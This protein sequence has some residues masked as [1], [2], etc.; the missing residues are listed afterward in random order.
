MFTKKSDYSILSL[1]LGLG[2]LYLLFPSINPSGDTVTYA[3]NIRSGDELFYPHHLLYNAFYY[4]FAE[5]L[6]SGNTLRLICAGNA[7][8]AAGCLFLVNAIL[9]SAVERKMRAAVILLLGSCF[10]FMRYAT[11]GETYIVPLFFL[12]AGSFLAFRK[13]NVFWVAL[14]AS[15]ACL[16]HQIC[17]FWWLGLLLFILMSDN[18]KWFRALTVY[19]FT[20]CIIPAVYLLVFYLTENDA[21]SI[22]DY[23]VHDYTHSEGVDFS[24]KTKA[25]LLTPIN[26]IRT[27][28]QV[29]GYILP[30]VQKY[31]FL[32]I[33]GCISG[34]LAIAGCIRWRKRSVGVN[35]V[36][37]ERKFALI[38]LVIFGLQL[39]FAF[40]S[41]GN[42]E[43][44][45]MLPFELALFVFFY[46]RVQRFPVALFAASLFI[47]NTA[48]GLL[49]MH[50]VEVTTQPALSRYIEQHPENIYYIR[51]RQTVNS[52]LEYRD[53]QKAYS[54]FQIK[55]GREVFLDSLLQHHPCVITDLFS[56]LAM[57]RA[58]LV[59]PGMKLP[60]DMNIC[61]QD[62]LP[63]DLGFFV[64]TEIRP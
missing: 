14:P 55:P 35:A 38:H 41:D 53:P 12:L 11:T 5:L 18:R 7:L 48:I 13:K 3:G 28:Y 33:F 26:L 45:V 57:S 54:I 8:F 63:F 44:M 30:L 34:L 42:A 32:I 39:L 4:L 37:F 46:Y 23:L 50:F 15:I 17:I 29:H 56:P 43:F 64:L 60:S 59:A 2:I 19:G 21:S 49:P 36:S 31:S 61:N 47:W 10:G 62:T 1:I 22:Y 6:G 27:F 58:A 25:F 51:D 16:F 24:V 52:Y 9:S 40:M 20:S